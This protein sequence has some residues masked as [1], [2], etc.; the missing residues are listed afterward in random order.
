MLQCLEI[1]AAQAIEHAAPELGVAAD[2]VV[3]V[4]EELGAVSVEPALGG[5]IAQVLPDSLGIPVVGFLR[6]GLPRSSTS[7]RAGDC[8]NARAM[9]PP[10]APLPMMMTSKSCSL[11]EL[12]AGVIL[13]IVCGGRGPMEA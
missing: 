7:T 9:V 1:L 12:A 4:R 8:D 2:A 11:P 10:P 5:S 13:A 6:D 3:R